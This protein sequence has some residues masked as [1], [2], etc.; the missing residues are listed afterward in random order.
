MMIK[1][2]TEKPLTLKAMQVAFGEAW[3]ADRHPKV[4]MASGKTFKAMTNVLGADRQWNGAQLV[5]IG[6][7]ADGE[8]QFH[9]PEAPE[10]NVTLV[11][12]AA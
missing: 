9:V 6:T 5:D 11:N 4:I 2:L 10:Q 8:I 12:V 1:N 3:V 7:V